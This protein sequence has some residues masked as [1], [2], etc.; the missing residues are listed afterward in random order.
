MLTL[1][2]YGYPSDMEK[3]GSTETA[4]YEI[5]VQGLLEQRWCHWFEGMHIKANPDQCETI[6]TGMVID[7]AALHGLLARIRDLGLI[8]LAL[9][10]LEKDKK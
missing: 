9:Y 4:V 8:L 1:G 7:Q 10:R 5:H 3:K 6:I 2:V